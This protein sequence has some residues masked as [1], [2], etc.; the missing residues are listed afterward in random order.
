MDTGAHWQ[1]PALSVSSH[2]FANGF[3][4]GESCQVVVQRVLFSRPAEYE[5]FVTSVATG[6]TLANYG[7]VP[8]SDPDQPTDTDW[9]E[10]RKFAEEKFT[11]EWE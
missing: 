10:A 2:E 11:G 9:E 1:R 6:K 3:L 7:T 4:E 5:A 8:L